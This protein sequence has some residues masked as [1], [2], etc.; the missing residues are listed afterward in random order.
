MSYPGGSRTTP[1]YR[2]SATRCNSGM[3][4]IVND[5][6]LISTSPA[7][8]SSPNT[9]LTC[10]GVRPV[11]SAMWRW[12]SGKSNVWHPHRSP[13]GDLLGQPEN[14]TG[15][16]LVSPPAPQIERQLVGPSLSLRSIEPEQ[17]F[18]KI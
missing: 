18:Q 8:C 4:V 13:F 15:D 17:L 5:R 6:L 1:R 16:P 10:T 3:F 7:R 14:Q 2:Q 12:R 11:A 9:L